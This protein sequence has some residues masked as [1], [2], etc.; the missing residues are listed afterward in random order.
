MRFDRFM[1]YKPPEIHP[2]AYA[3]LRVWP[4]RASPIAYRELPDG[5]R[6][7]P[8]DYVLMLANLW[9]HRCSVMRRADATVH[10]DKAGKY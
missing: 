10:Q 7:R 5:R 1:S 3:L 2:A 4:G 8:P 9:C 6:E